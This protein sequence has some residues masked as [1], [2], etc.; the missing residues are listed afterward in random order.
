MMQTVIAIAVNE[1]ARRDIPGSTVANSKTPWPVNRTLGA[2]IHYVDMYAER[3][4]KSKCRVCLINR[5][6]VQ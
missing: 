4:V 3:S 1:F 6:I 5:L 2:Q